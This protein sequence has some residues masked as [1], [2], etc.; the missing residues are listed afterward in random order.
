MTHTVSR[1]R[2]PWHARPCQR[3]RPQGRGPTP[4]PAALGA[5]L[6]AGALIGLA[7]CAA[8]GSARITVSDLA[9]PADAPRVR[10]DRVLNP[11]GDRS[12]RLLSLVTGQP[13]EPVLQRPYG[14]AWDGDA[15]LLTDPG[16]GAVLRIGAE[17]RVLA[18][19]RSALTSP[20][21]VASCPQGIVVT[22]S[23]RGDLVLLDR[24]LEVADRLATGLA[25]P[26]GV[27]CS[28]TEIFVAETGAHRILVLSGGERRVL[29]RR[30]S[31]AGEFNFPTSLAFDAGDLWVG[32]TLNFRVQRID[33]A[34][35]TARESF[36]R[37]GDTAGEM[38]RLKGVAVD[39]AG[40]LWVTD[41]LLDAVSMFSSDGTYLLS[42]GAN[43][44]A[45]G[46]F[47][48]PAGVAASSSGELAVVDSF[49]RRVQIFRLVTPEVGR[50]S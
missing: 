1:R 37:L 48:F 18:A 42:V 13:R 31:G 27:A 17:G 8:S 6:L 26:T 44:D 29:G 2:E 16:A 33:A 22:D 21:G 45:P 12:G 30:G 46:Q 32:D 41:A 40:Q 49:N 10:L 14:V 23:E 3:E 38:P 7:G 5:C 28:A 9:W 36:G 20:I 39:G 15:L 4:V 50:S 47:S 43:G 34:T 35:G 11:Q 19:N 25:R 24:H